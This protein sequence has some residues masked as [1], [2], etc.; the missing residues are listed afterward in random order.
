M[1][2]LRRKI[3]EFIFDDEAMGITVAAPWIIF[4]CFLLMVLVFNLLLWHLQKEQLQIVADS[5]SRAG[6]LA[7][8]KEYATREGGQY[9]VYVEL[10]P[11]EANSNAAEVVDAYRDVLGPTDIEYVAYNPSIAGVTYPVWSQRTRSYFQSPLS[12]YDQYFN[13]NFSVYLRGR[14]R[15]IWANALGLSDNFDIQTFSSS[16]ARGSAR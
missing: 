15:G 7:V 6:T 12:P 3:K 13:G 11:G 14:I 1:D 9:H 4:L 16:H 5:A 10:D 8:A 2:N